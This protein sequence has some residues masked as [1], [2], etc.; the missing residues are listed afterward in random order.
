[1]ILIKPLRFFRCNYAVNGHIAFFGLINAILI[2]NN[3][4]ITI[5]EFLNISNIDY[6]FFHFNR[7]RNF[8]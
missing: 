4:K 2:V 1:M 3:G 8:A 7:I 6:R 5:V